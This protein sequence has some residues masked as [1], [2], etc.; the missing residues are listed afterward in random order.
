M[1]DVNSFNH[2]DDIPQF[3]KDRAQD[4]E[5]LKQ[6]SMWQAAINGFFHRSAWAKELETSRPFHT[7]GGASRELFT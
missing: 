1:P 3:A 4:Q 2:L 5:G 6:L 7:T